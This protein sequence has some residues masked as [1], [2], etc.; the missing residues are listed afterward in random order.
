MATATLPSVGQRGPLRL[1]LDQR[2]DQYSTDI[3]LHLYVLADY[4]PSVQEFL[5]ACFVL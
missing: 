3:W 5:R 4:Y 1:E 2:C